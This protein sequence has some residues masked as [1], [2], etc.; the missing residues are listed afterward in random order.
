MNRGRAWTAAIVALIVGRALASCTSENTSRTAQQR[1][2]IPS[3][4]SLSSDAK[5]YAMLF[6]DAWRDGDNNQLTD[7]TTPSAVD[8]LDPLSRTLWS[9]PGFPELRVERMSAGHKQQDLID[10]SLKDGH[11]RTESA[12]LAAA[13]HRI[14]ELEEVKSG[15]AAC[16]VELWG[17]S[18]AVTTLRP[19]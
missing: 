13:R 3:L 14:R 17:G 10:R 18:M 2:H 16:S 5:A 15:F 1:A 9:S 7:L 8:E 19:P 4:G 11:G 6:M 12:E